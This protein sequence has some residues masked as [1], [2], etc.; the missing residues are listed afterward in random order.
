[1][2]EQYQM[3]PDKLRELMGEYELDQIRNDL[4]IQAAVKLVTDL[5]VEK[6]ASEEAE[7]A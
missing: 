1:M 7:E 3:E 4:L 2:A 5:A 6:E